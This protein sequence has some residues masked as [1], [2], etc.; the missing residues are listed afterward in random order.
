MDTLTPMKVFTTVALLLLSSCASQQEKKSLDE[1]LFEY[2]HGL[3]W[4]RYDYVTAYLPPRVRAAFLQRAERAKGLRVTRCVVSTT[5]AVGTEF[6]VVV[7]LDWF[8]LHQGRVRTT[9]IAQRWKHEE[10]GWKVA[11]QRL[12]SGAALPLLVPVV[13]LQNDAS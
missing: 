6:E 2:T 1:A 3:R 12:L 13:A 10:Q 8:W 7:A 11:R 9:R 5:R 4:S